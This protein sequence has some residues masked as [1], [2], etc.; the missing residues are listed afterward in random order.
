MPTTR[1]QRAMQ[2]PITSQSQLSNYTDCSCCGE[3]TRRPQGADLSVQVQCEN[4]VPFSSPTPL[5]SLGE[6]FI[7]G[8]AP[9]DPAPTL[10]ALDP[11]YT[12][13]TNPAGQISMFQ[14]WQEH[15]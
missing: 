13:P 9:S 5:S 4:C 1:S 15:P 3:L 12:L 8:P 14:R 2:S 6:V 7:P 10:H 11:L